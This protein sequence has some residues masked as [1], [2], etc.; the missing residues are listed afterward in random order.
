MS[1]KPMALETLADTFFVFLPVK[2]IVDLHR[3]VVYFL[4]HFKLLVAN[5]QMQ[6]FIMTFECCVFA[7]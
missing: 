1:K 4:D 3:K 6:F 7:L 2:R 5:F